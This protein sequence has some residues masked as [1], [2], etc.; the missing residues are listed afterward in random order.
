ML[1]KQ[2]A[3]SAAR[4]A[5]S[6]ARFEALSEALRRDSSVTLAKMFG[7]NGFKIH[8]KVFAMLVKGTLVVKLSRA[9]AQTLVASGRAVPFDPGHGR[10]MKEWVAIP[11]EDTGTWLDL[12]E[13]AKALVAR[14]AG[15]RP[16]A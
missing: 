8:G 15:S 16:V 9:R 12:A 2:K 11:P 1:G 5:T 10:I 7:S 6:D 14:S 4:Q 13:E 3:G